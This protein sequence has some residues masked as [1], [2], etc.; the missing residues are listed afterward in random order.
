MGVE[1]TREIIPIHVGL[2]KSKVWRAQKRRVANPA[3][4]AEFG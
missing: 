1:K 4:G 2:G 3:I